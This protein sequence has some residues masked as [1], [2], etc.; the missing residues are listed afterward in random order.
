MPLFACEG[1]RATFGS[2]FCFPGLGGHDPAGIL[3][4]GRT[5]HLTGSVFFRKACTIDRIHVV[6]GFGV[7]AQTDFISNDIRVI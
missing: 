1:Q 5:P 3:R 2:Q 7:L 4:R 6:L